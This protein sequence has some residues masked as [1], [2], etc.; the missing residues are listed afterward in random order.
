MVLEHKTTGD[1]LDPASNYWRRL[2]VDEQ[3]GEYFL[4]CRQEMPGDEP[5]GILYDVLKRPA[6]GRLKAVAAVDEDGLKIVIDRATNRRAINTRTGEWKKT[7]GKDQFIQSAPETDAQYAKRLMTDIYERPD[8]YYARKEIPRSIQQLSDAQKRLWMTAQ[9]MNYTEKK[10]FH[11]K[12]S[13]SCLAPWPCAYLDPCSMDNP[14]DGELPEGYRRVDHV[15]Q[16]L[17]NGK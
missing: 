4:A 8:F 7:A 2:A 10:G 15:H 6:M 13:H 9:E 5:Q 16:E 14:L 12:N 11:R 3:I 1:T 17:S